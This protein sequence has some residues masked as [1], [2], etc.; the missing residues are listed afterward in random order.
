MLAVSCV[1]VLLIA[2]ALRRRGASAH[3]TGEDRAK[4]RVPLVAVLPIR[5]RDLTDSVTLTAELRPW[6]TAKLYAKV[7][8]YLQS[9][10]VDYG[11][12]VHSGET[13]AKLELPEQSADLERKN[14]EYQ[15]AKMT[16]D[17]LLSVERQTP[18]MLARQDIDNAQAAYEAAKDERDR[19]AVVLDYTNIVAPF[20]GIVTKREV[21]PGALIT[22]GIGGSAPPLVEIADE[23]TLRLVLDVPESLVEKI[24][25]GTPVD[26]SVS[27]IGLPIHA[28]VSRIA[29]NVQGATRTEHTEVDIDNGALR[30][31]PGMYA[32]A[33]IVLSRA[34]HVSSVPPETVSDDG[35]MIVVDHHNVVR[36]RMVTIGLRT[37]KW[38]QVVSGIEPGDRVYVGDASSVSIGTKVAVI[39]QVASGA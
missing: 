35:L 29:Y 16:Y 15:L 9:I 2:G 38:I 10:S 5:Q 7:S 18:G 25:V 26:V 20:D 33:S 1:A 11:S 19:A 12:R 17:R 21:D 3:S 37:P 30:I 13:I 4:E 28:A 8:G 32:N 6:N 27:G 39:Q 22:Q 36:R 31:K 23:R 34:E 24:H 14:T